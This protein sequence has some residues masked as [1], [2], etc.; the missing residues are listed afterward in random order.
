M[1]PL[2]D[3]GGYLEVAEGAAALDVVHAK[4][5]GLLFRYLSCSRFGPPEPTVSEY[6]SLGAGL[7]AFLVVSGRC[8][9]RSLIRSSAL[10]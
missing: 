2:G 3:I 6:S 1:A 8:S 4:W 7:P 10:D 5:V 9:R